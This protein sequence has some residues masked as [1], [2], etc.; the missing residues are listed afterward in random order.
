[1]PCEP[2]WTMDSTGG[3][4]L[5]CGP[6]DCPKVFKQGAGGKFEQVAAKC[7]NV[8]EYAY[9]PKRSV[10]VQGM[11]KCVCVVTPIGDLCKLEILTDGQTPPKKLTS[12]K[13]LG[14]GCGQFFEGPDDKKPI[15]VRCKM[16]VDHN[17]NHRL[18]CLCII[19]TK[20]ELEKEREE[21]EEKDRKEKEEKEK[22]EKEEKEKKEKEKK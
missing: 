15:T 21:K 7:M 17:D 12:V 20:E 1:M 22:K 3:L 5:S 10:F 6:D 19:I 11:Q 4:T 2:K 18:K 16:V 8:T 9:D 14:Q 13:C